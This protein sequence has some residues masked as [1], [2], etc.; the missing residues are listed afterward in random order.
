M[1]SKGT[2]TLPAHIRKELGLKKIGDKLML[3]YHQKNQSVE[4]TK[5]PDFATMRAEL[6]KKLP[7]D[8]PPFDLEEIRRQKHEEYFRDHLA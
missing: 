2:F 4:L 3:T 7:K 5:A 1:T 6:A 8:L